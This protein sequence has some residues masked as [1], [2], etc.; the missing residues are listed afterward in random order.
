MR[1]RR[2]SNDEPA[3]KKNGRR[4]RKLRLLALVLVLGLL[5]GFLMLRFRSLSACVVAH[6]AHNAWALYVGS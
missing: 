3:R 2:S 4:I 1:F 5:N 6:A